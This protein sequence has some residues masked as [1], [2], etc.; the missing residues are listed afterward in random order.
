MSVR[1][2]LITTR[3]HALPGSTRQGPLAG[4]ENFSALN[5]LGLGSERPFVSAR[6]VSS[7]A[8]TLTSSIPRNTRH[9]RP[10]LNN[11]L[12]AGSQPALNPL[13]TLNPR[14]EPSE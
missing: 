9:S 5:R 11:P 4:S 3:P 12:S 6:P 13:S 8:S 7:S 10:A 2:N 1:Q 14:L